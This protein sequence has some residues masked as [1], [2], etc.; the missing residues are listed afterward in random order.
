MNSLSSFT[1]TSLGYLIALFVPGTA[2]IYAAS[3][4]S[5]PLK[6]VL[7][8]FYVSGSGV[9]LFL[10]VMM[11]ALGVGMVLMAV[12]GFIYEWPIEKRFNLNGVTAQEWARL[13]DESNLPALRAVVDEMYRY[14]QCWGA[15]SLVVPVLLGYFLG[16]HIGEWSK[17]RFLCAVVASAVV[18]GILVWAAVL[19]YKRYLEQSQAVLR[20]KKTEVTNA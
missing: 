20:G 11:A 16:H 14:H 7:R 8:T 4:F 15:L 1:S 6:R 12:R 2:G 19:S 17:P 5:D 3:L 18:W 10:L 13:P 9:G